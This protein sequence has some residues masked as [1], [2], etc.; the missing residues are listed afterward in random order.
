[1]RSEKTHGPGGLLSDFYK[2]ACLVPQ[3]LHSKY[4]HLSDEGTE[5]PRTGLFLMPPTQLINSR[6]GTRTWVE[7]PL[8]SGFS[9]LSLSGVVGSPL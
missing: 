7:V 4:H 3:C 8:K 9:L 5:A 1:M 2:C 6:L